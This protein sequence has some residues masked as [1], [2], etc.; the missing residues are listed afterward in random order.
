[1]NI[2]LCTIS[3][4]DVETSVHC[5]FVELRSLLDVQEKVG[6]VLLIVR[7]FT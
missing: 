3:A 4:A 5:I 7:R 2:P 1:M 6:V